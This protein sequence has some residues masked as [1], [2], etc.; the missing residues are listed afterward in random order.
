[1]DAESRADASVASIAAAI[2]EPAR[3]KMLYCLLDRRARTATELAAAGDITASTASAHLERLRRAG[4]VRVEAQ[5]RHRY[6]RLAGSDVARALERLSVLAGDSRR[7][8]VPSTPL[9]LRAARTCY[10]HIAG[11]LGVALHDGL[12]RAGWLSARYEVTAQGAAAMDKLGVDVERA[13]KA[14]RRFAYP[15][16]DWSERQPHLGGALGAELLRVALGRRWVI[17]ELDSRALSVTRA[18][19]REMMA[20]WGVEVDTVCV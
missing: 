14:R 1:M 5:G 10:D 8:F 16:L 4:L 15:C 9:R 6:F 19:R 17:Q 18:G 7:K 2:G 12:R 13:R 11:T 20:R 3:V